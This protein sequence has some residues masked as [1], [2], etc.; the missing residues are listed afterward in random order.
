MGNLHPVSDLRKL[1]LS[2]KDTH[3]VMLTFEDDS[4]SPHL[5]TQ[6]LTA[7]NGIGEG[8]EIDF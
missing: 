3:V 5:K 6:P 4:L 7:Y 8:C 1:P 2:V